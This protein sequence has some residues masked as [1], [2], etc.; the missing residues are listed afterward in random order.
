[1]LLAR[2]VLRIF[3][4]DFF[5][6][7]RSGFFASFFFARAIFT[8]SLAPRTVVSLCRFGSGIFVGAL[9]ISTGD[10]ILDIFSVC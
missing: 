1:M 9:M 7:L 5:P 3:A 4:T 8:F 6:A 2:G 10:G